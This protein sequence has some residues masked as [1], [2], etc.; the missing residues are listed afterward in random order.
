M[1]AREQLTKE[2]IEKRAHQLYEERGCREGHALDD[3]IDAER[4]LNQ[5]E[6]TE[7]FKTASAGNTRS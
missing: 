3:W 2:Q 4:E 7:R 6:A 1:A 5:T